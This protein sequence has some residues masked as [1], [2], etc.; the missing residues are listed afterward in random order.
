[1]KIVWSKVHTQIADSGELEYQ[2]QYDK[3]HKNYQVS[4]RGDGW[5]RTWVRIDGGDL[6]TLEAAERWVEKYVRDHQ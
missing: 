6:E 3:D 1:M 5:S 4:Y 2:I